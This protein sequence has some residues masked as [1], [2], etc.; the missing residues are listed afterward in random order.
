MSKEKS[1]D[2]I[3]HHKD[4][5]IEIL[6]DFLTN[7]AGVH[8][9][10]TDLIS[11]WLHTY[12]NYIK[13]EDSF[14]PKKNKRY[15]RGEIVKVDFGFNVGSEYGGLHYAVVLDKKNDRSSPV[16]TVIPL[17]STDNKSISNYNIDLGNE[18]YLQLRTKMLGMQQSYKTDKESMRQMISSL[19]TVIE[20]IKTNNISI[21]EEQF[22]DLHNTL[23]DTKNRSS[24]LSKKQKEISNMLY[25]LNHMKSGS[26]ALVSQIRCISKIRIVD[27]VTIHGV[28]NGI[29]L[30][31]E[32]MDKIDNRILT[33]FTKG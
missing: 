20:N 33:L 17:S 6:N 15:E 4:K 26:M 18:L 30:S 22:K 29:K 13:F 19:Q 2:E 11:Y 3:L 28:L 1:K 7:L 5:T 25:E 9:K 10:K 16:I 23:D 12:T 21:S 32:N 24:A 27:P 8:P 31:S 14:D